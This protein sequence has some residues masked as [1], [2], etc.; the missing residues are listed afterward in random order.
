MRIQS[1][2]GGFNNKVDYLSLF[3]YQ[4]KGENP[5][6]GSGNSEWFGLS[7]TKVVGRKN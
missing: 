6:D 3:L 7:E 4:I 1:I 2:F 5:V